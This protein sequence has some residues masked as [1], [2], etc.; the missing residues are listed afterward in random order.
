[1]AELGLPLVQCKQKFSTMDLDLRN[2]ILPLF[3]EKADKYALD[4]ITYGSYVASYGYRN[5][6]CAADVV[7]ACMAILEQHLE[8]TGDSKE[9]ES[10]ARKKAAN[11]E[12]SKVY[13]LAKLKYSSSRVG[14]GFMSHTKKC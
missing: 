5:K 9:D 1:M 8:S 7:Y 11:P 6:F 4:D 12:K 3:E 13:K 2:Q 10:V 14:S